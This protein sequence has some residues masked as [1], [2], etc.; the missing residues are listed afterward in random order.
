MKQIMQKVFSKP[1]QRGF[2]EYFNGWERYGVKEENGE[3]A[4][5]SPDEIHTIH[6]IMKQDEGFYIGPAEDVREFYKLHK[7]L[8][9]KE[10]EQHKEGDRWKPGR[11]VVENTPENY[12]VWVRHKEELKDKGTAWAKVGANSRLIHYDTECSV[13]KTLAPMEQ[14]M[15]KVFG[16]LKKYYDGK[17]EFGVYREARGEK[18]AAVWAVEPT[19]DSIGY[20]RAMN[21]QDKH[22]F[23]RP[24]FDSESS[25]MLHDDLDAQGLAKYHQDGNG[26]WKP[27]RLV[28]ES[29]P[30]N[31]QV[32]IKCDRALSVDEKKHWLARMH[33]DPGASPLHRWG[34]C[35]GF[36]NRKEKYATDKG[37]PLARLHWIDWQG[38]AHIPAV[39]I[40]KQKRHTPGHKS[41][42]RI[43]DNGRLPTRDQ[44][45]KGVDGKGKPRESEQDFAYMLAL[46][47]RGVDEDTIKQRIRSER[48]DWENHSGE[49]RMERYLND[50]LKKAK[51]IIQSTGYTI[52]FYDKDNTKLKT[53]LV[54]KIPVGQH[55]KKSLE[56]WAKDIVVK[57]GY[58]PE[59]M[60]V[61]IK[62]H[63]NVM[64]RGKAKEL[65]RPPPSNQKVL[66]LGKAAPTQRPAG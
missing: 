1:F 6:R 20:L 42:R 66:L 48:T 10:L 47:R 32:W 62:K 35:P 41:G 34:R 43:H 2:G 60:R 44:Y 50:S 15:Q 59:G 63:E 61:D 37:F 16:K 23:I 14:G 3:I 17:F 21:A 30:G 19:E 53:L 39:E 57:E 13:E 11:F 56:Q 8:T 24:S 5:V 25:Y 31:F 55:H 27:G 38:R 33:S 58:N 49:K 9:K 22:I 29:S 51:S 4:E 26:N 18:E 64:S 65:N 54:S 12:Q 45:F 36:R 28:V 7:D 52:N 40:K 46:L